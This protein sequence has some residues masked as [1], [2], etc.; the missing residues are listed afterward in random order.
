MSKAIDGSEVTA[1]GSSMLQVSRQPR[2]TSYMS[3]SGTSPPFVA[4]AADGDY[5]SNCGHE[6]VGESHS[7]AAKSKHSL[8]IPG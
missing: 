3:Q 8:L 7:A 1:G 5:P 6:S 4:D 2:G